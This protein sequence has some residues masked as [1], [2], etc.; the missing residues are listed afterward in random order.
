MFQVGAG[1]YKINR[2][3]GP[4]IEYSGRLSNVTAWMVSPGV[5]QGMKGKHAP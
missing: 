3:D 4:A 5:G 2:K 1:V